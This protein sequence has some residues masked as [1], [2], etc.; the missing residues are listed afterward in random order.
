VARRPR[1]PPLAP[2]L[3]AADALLR[4]TQARLDA[5]AAATQ[6]ASDELA[7]AE[8]KRGRPYSAP[9]RA[10]RLRG[11]LGGLT[12]QQARGKKPGEHIVRRER[13]AREVSAGK[14]GLTTAQR[15]AVSRF[16]R[17]QARRI[18]DSDP[19]ELRDAAVDLFERK[20]YAAFVRVKAARDAL[21]AKG[22]GTL[23]GGRGRSRRGVPSAAERALASELADI[24][25]DDG[26]DF[27][28]L[29]FYG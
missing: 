5:L 12:P 27:D 7:R 19:D 8:S 22:K 3:S 13:E 10:R 11:I 1:R 26:G 21:A 29:L 28:W 20:G 24:L 23:G 4:D 2:E 14:R 15:Q 6:A 25:G 9:Y 17:Q 18:A 16:A